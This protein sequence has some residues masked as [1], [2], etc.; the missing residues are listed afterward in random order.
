MKT[1]LVD[2]NIILYALNKDTF[3]EE[4]ARIIDLCEKRKLKG[5][6]CAHEITT[7]SY[8]LEKKSKNIKKNKFIISNILDIFSVLNINKEILK[9]ALFSE[10]DDYEDAVIDVSALH[11]EIDYIVTKNMKDFKKSKTKVLTPGEFL[12]LEKI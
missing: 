2:L 4:S 9:E 3:F 11:N 8:F 1:I 10:I 7:L 5:Y 6:V 12:V